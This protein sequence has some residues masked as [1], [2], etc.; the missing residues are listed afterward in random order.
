MQL[1]APEIAQPGRDRL[2]CRI[3]AKE[4][5]LRVSAKLHKAYVEVTHIMLAT[6]RVVNELM[7]K[8][9]FWPFIIDVHEV[10]G[11]VRLDLA[12]LFGV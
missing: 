1:Q 11:V 9:R 4:L 8:P 6:Q 10:A 3:A 12:P 7:R 2:I 5:G